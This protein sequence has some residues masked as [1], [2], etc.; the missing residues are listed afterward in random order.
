V[1]EKSGTDIGQG[2]GIWDDFQWYKV[3]AKFSENHST[4]M[5]I[6]EH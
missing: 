4:A 1:W 2:S 3:H 6:Y 5:P